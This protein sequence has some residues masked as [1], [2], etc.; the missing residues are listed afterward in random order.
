[1]QANGARA[2]IA[3]DTG[4][5]TTDGASIESL[6]IIA[7]GGQDLVDVGDL[8]PTP[9]LDVTADLGFLDGARDTIALQGTDAFDNIGLRPFNDAVR[10]DGL[11]SMVTIENA[12]AGDD[13]LSVLGRGGIDLI[14]ADRATGAKLPSRSRVGPARTSSKA[15]TPPTRCAAARMPTS[16]RAGRATTS[17]TWATATIASAARRPTATIASRAA[18]A[19]TS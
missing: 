19:S 12:V 9:V 6:D 3:R 11:G 14:T 10:V 17:S 18:T 16:S 2:R 8:S 4:P 15:P 1:M 13:H 7:A 5:A